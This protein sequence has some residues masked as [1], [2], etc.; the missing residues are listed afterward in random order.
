MRWQARVLRAK[1]DNK[2]PAVVERSK[3]SK[4]N[5]TQVLA[6]LGLA[7]NLRS[8]AIGQ[9]ADQG[10]QEGQV[11]MIYA[12]RMEE[13]RVRAS[14]ME[15]FMGFTPCYGGLSKHLIECV[16]EKD[17]PIHLDGKDSLP[18]TYL[19]PNMQQQ[20]SEKPA[21]K[22]TH[23]GAVINGIDSPQ[24]YVEVIPTSSSGCRLIWI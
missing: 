9:G 21:P 7:I 19:V 23:R 22:G 13:H 12:I 15:N 16:Q 14:A 11:G 17:V 24:I 10:Q 20:V 18:D 1:R 2:N 6:R 5:H 4:W 3:K 8:K